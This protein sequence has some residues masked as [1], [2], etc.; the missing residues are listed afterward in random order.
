[1]S[2]EN[3]D[4]AARAYAAYNTDGVEGIIE[5]LDP[6]IEWRMW[7]QFAREP[8]VYQGHA[9][10]RE[11][12]GV[13]TENFEEFGADPHEFIDAGDKVVVPVRLHGT[14]KGSSEESSFELV[15]VWTEGDGGRARRLDVYDSKE[16]ALEAAGL[17]PDD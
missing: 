6:E 5:F 9:G 13:F 1:M 17:K 3:V 11:A 15:Q 4:N 2:K 8:R 16:E 12:L 10:V 14:L 7:E